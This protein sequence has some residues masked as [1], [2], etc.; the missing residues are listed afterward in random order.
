MSMNPEGTETHMTLADAE[1]VFG[2]D[3]PPLPTHQST[4][5]IVHTMLGDFVFE[6]HGLPV[7]F[8]EF[9]DPTPF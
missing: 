6:V 7:D 4:L 9:G 1:A 5:I 2:V 3:F 8:P